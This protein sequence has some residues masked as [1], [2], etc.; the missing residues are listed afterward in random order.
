MASGGAASSMV[1]AGELRWNV[2]HEKISRY[3]NIQVHIEL[4]GFTGLEYLVFA[5]ESSGGKTSLND[6]YGNWSY[7]TTCFPFCKEGLFAEETEAHNSTINSTNDSQGSDLLGNA[8]CPLLFNRPGTSCESKCK[9]K[10]LIDL[11]N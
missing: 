4:P 9:I 1:L 7:S 6:T 10:S 11:C 2:R 5:L 3:K 8:S